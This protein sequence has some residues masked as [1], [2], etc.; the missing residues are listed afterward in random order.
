MTFAVGLCDYII[1]WPEGDLKIKGRFTFGSH[2]GPF[3]ITNVLFVV[4]K[5]NK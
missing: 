3:Y 4:K 1:L 5:T 2:V